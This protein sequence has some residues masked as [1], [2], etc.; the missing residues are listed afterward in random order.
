MNFNKPKLETET[1]RVYVE[2][3]LVICEVNEN[4]QYMVGVFWG[5]KF[6]IF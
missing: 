2:M 5:L 6:E 3:R 4:S 1:V